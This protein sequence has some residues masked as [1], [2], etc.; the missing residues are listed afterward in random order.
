MNLTQTIDGKKFLSSIIETALVNKLQSYGFTAV[1]VKS[2]TAKFVEFKVTRQGIE[3]SIYISR[4]SGLCRKKIQVVISPNLFNEI[5]KKIDSR[6]ISLNINKKCKAHPRY[7]FNS[8]F[9]AFKNRFKVSYSKEPFGAS[10][11]IDV[12]ESLDGV[13]KF[14][15][16]FSF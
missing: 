3:E 5:D 11:W 10:Y 12:K 6:I 16:I 8:N 2:I 7:I 14:T 13:G 4:N 9:S 1:P 15:E